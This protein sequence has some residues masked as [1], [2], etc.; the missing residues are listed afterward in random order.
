MCVGTSIDCDIFNPLENLSVEEVSNLTTDKFKELSYQ[1]QVKNSHH[2]T[3]QLVQRINGA[4]C[5]GNYIKGRTGLGQ[6]DQMLGFL[7]PYIQDILAASDLAL[8]PGGHFVQ[9][10]EVFASSHSTRG[11]LYSELAKEK[12]FL[13]DGN[14]C[15]KC[16]ESPQKPGEKLVT[17]PQP[18]V[19][20]E[21]SS[22]L[23][24]SKSS[25]RDKSIDKYL[26]RKNF[27]QLFHTG[28]LEGENDILAFSNNFLVE[29]KFIEKRI[30]HLKLLQL[31]KELRKKE[32]EAKRRARIVKEFKDYNWQEEIES[33]NFKNLVVKDLKKYCDKYKLG[34][35]GR[36]DDLKNRVRG[37]W[38]TVKS[39]S[40]QVETI[41]P[42]T[43]L[44]VMIA[45][46]EADIVD[47]EDYENVDSDNDDIVNCE[48]FSSNSDTSDEE[49]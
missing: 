13:L 15:A 26:P 45:D 33:N 28:K 22:Y 7:K 2:I 23:D 27:D 42:Q 21:T 30:Q 37:H 35:G 41:E 18:E 38:F 4:P 17:V 1:A 19:D 36:K 11:L 34:V 31:K 39:G 5:L 14:L 20:P 46:T 43:L 49:N 10:L 48:H 24:V 29:R 47:I 16:I 9:E 12:C 3:D 32:T 40:D 25:Y 6:E 44:A 8:V